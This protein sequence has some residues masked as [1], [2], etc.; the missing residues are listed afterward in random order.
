LSTTGS[1]SERQ[2]TGASNDHPGWM[3]TEPVCVR[4]VMLWAEL[5]ARGTATW[6]LPTVAL[7]WMAYATPR[8]SRRD[9]DP[10]LVVAATV[11]GAAEKET[12]MLP[13]LVLSAALAEDM[14][15]PLIDPARSLTWTAPDSDLRAMPPALVCT[16]TWPVRAVSLMLPTW[17]SILTMVAGGMR[18]WYST[19]H[20]WWTGQVP[21][22]VRVPART[23]CVVAGSWCR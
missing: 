4:A 12:S 18:T 23:A 6:T 3:V 1:V 14:P 21:V 15:E 5:L 13:T 10:T 22:R 7:A 20:G 9:M 19:S 2:L 11:A 17:S 16:T 8:G